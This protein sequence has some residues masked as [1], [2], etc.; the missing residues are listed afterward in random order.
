MVDLHLFCTRKQ[1][2]HGDYSSVGLAFRL[3]EI[4]TH[5]YG[6]PHSQNILKPTAELLDRRGVHAISSENAGPSPRNDWG[7]SR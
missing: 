6:W 1:V 7:Q 4:L 5:C 2:T 3:F